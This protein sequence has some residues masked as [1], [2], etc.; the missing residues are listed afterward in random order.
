MKRSRI[1][2]FVGIVFAILLIVSLFVPYFSEDFVPGSIWESSEYVRIPLLISYIAII[3][4]LLINIRTDICNFFTGF[5]FFYS[6]IYMIRAGDSDYGFEIFGVGF[7]LMF[8]SSLLLAI[9]VFVMNFKVFD[10][11]IGANK[12]SSNYGYGNYNAGSVGNFVPQNPNPG[13][14]QGKI[15]GYNPMTGEPIYEQV[16]VR[17]RKILRYDPMTGEPIYE[18]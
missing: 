9:L 2:G 10:K 17:E 11:K 3:I 18:D 16:A 7:W 13:N 5:P 8:I 1:F 14:V 4:V 6:I 15:V 12:N